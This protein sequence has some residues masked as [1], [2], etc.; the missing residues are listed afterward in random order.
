MLTCTCCGET[1]EDVDYVED[2]PFC[3]EYCAD[4]YLHGIIP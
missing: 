4:F 2:L 1:S 3:S